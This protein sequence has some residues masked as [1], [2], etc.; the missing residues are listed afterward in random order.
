MRLDILV[1]FVG[2]VVFIFVNVEMI[3]EESGEVEREGDEFLVY[4]KRGK[5]E[6]MEDWF[7]V[8]IN[9]ERDFK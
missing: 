1:V 7:F 5:R 9:F 6:V 3:R 4:C 8:I 2:V